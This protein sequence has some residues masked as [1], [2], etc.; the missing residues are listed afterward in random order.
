MRPILRSRGSIPEHETPSSNPASVGLKVQGKFRWRAKTDIRDGVPRVI[1][2]VKTKVSS[3][4][5]SNQNKPSSEEDSRS[6]S[7]RINLSAS[8]DA[9]RLED[10]TEPL[11]RQ[12]G[13]QLCHT[14]KAILE[15]ESPTPPPDQENQGSTRNRALSADTWTSSS[16][17]ASSKSSKA[18]APANTVP[19]PLGR[20]LR[21]I[22]SAG[23]AHASSC[24]NLLCRP[25]WPS[26]KVAPLGL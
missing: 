13:E 8:E 26:L 11:L 1:S 15:P 12:D 20:I 14:N 3:G 7:H 4:R 5:R 17:A 18:S 16:L 19:G 2:K 6:N 24:S 23:K 10:N 25:K 9:N 22:I 21:G